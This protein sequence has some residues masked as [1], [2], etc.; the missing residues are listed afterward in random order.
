V[1]LF[2]VLCVLE[3]TGATQHVDQ[4][5]R[6]WMFPGGRWGPAQARSGRVVARLDPEHL[7]VVSLAVAVVVSAV[8]RSPAPLLFAVAT[9]ALAA[10]CVV[11]PKWVMGHLDP[12]LDLQHSIASFP[13][14][15]MAGAIVFSGQLVLLLRRSRL[16]FWVPTVA[17]AV[18]MSV[19]LQVS[20]THRLS[21]VVGG[22][23]IGVGVLV[24]ASTWQLRSWAQGGPPPAWWVRL[25]GRARSRRHLAEPEIGDTSPTSTGAAPGRSSGA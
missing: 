17:L 19:V 18:L 16:L 11:L 12:M 13:S 20:A 21:E 4:V 9:T 3:V 1:L 2:L 5:V 8:R 7:L 15:H 22:A 25:V 10:V 23:L 24:A 14:G 6:D